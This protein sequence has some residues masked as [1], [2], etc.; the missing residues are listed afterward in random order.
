MKNLSVLLMILFIT[1]CAGLKSIDLVANQ[2]TQVVGEDSEKVNVKIIRVKQV[3]ESVYVNGRVSRNNNDRFTKGYV[4]V[5]LYD[6]R[7]VRIDSVDATISFKR[8][9]SKVLRSGSFT[10]QLEEKPEKNSKVIVTA[11]D[12]RKATDSRAG[13]IKVM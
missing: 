7:G 12:K 6:E 3:N 5:D 2:T 1:G 13:S 9:G 10:V 4:T 11:H 8:N